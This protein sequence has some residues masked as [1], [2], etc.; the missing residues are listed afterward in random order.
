MQRLLALGCWGWVTKCLA[1]ES[2]SVTGLV[3]AHLWSE[4]GSGVVLV[5]TFSDILLA[6]LSSSHFL[7]WMAAG[8]KV[9]QSWCWLAGGGVLGPRLRG[10]GADVSLLVGKAVYWGL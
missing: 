8:S 7:T 1:E 4:Q 10:S 5:P 6:C 2:W 9:S 3:L